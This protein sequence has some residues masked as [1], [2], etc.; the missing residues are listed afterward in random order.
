MSDVNDKNRSTE[1]MKQ[2][3]KSKVGKK[4]DSKITHGAFFYYIITPDDQKL[5]H[6]AL[7]D[8]CVSGGRC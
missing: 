5:L 6:A 2:Q 1:L 3:K 4:L 7:P 8:S